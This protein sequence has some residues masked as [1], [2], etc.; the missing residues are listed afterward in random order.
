M[1]DSPDNRDPPPSL[2]PGQFALWAAAFEG[3]VGLAAIALGWLLGFRP[4]GLLSWSLRDLAWGATPPPHRW[5]SSGC[6][7]AFPSDPC[8]A[9]CEW[10]TRR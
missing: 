4:L 7:S 9:W 1:N 8:A 3:G 6:G 2:P 5:P 10:S